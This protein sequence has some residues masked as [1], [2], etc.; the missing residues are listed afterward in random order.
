LPKEDAWFY[1]KRWLDSLKRKRGGEAAALMCEMM[2]AHLATQKEYLGRK[3]HARH[4]LDYVRRCS[5]VKWRADQLRNV[6]G[7]LEEQHERK[8]LEEF[9]YTGLRKFPEVAYFHW[10]AGVLETDRGPI[11]CNWQL[12]RERL[13][14]AVEL[15]GDSNNRDDQRIVEQ[16]KRL[17]TMLERGPRPLHD[18]DDDDDFDGEEEYEESPPDEEAGAPFPDLDDLFELFQRTC[19]SMGIDPEDLFERFAAGQAASDAGDR[20]NA[21]RKRR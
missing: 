14:R 1:E 18:L 19:R 12:A 15:A 13:S 21:R 10:M 16:A 3:E 9:V 8:L 20:P 17:L 7:F 4:L 6:C 2:T 11:R 5:R